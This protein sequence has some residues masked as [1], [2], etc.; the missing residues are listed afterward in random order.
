M[1]PQKVADRRDFGPWLIRKFGLHIVR[2]Q[3]ARFRDNLDAT[4]DRAAQLEIAAVSGK[5]G[6]RHHLCHRVD[7]VQYVAQANEM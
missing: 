5:I 6:T 4:L 3:A 2:Y 1:V 7:I